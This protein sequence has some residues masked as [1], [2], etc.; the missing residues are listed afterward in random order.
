MK[1]SIT[2]E[3]KSKS[4]IKLSALN[5]DK[6]TLGAVDDTNLKCSNNKTNQNS[7]CKPTTYSPP[8]C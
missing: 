4:L 5:L 3:L 7:I 1:Q 8:M 6:N 2:E